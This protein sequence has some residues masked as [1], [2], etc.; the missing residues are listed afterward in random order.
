MNIAVFGSAFNPPTKGHEDAIH[1]L[2][3]SD[4]TFDCIFLIPSYRHAFDKKMLDYDT[5]KALLALFVKDINQNKVIA[6]PIE[7]ELDAGDKPVYTY[8]LLSHLENELGSTHRLTFIIGPDNAANWSKFYMADEIKKRW[9]T[10]VVPERQA[11]RSTLVRNKIKHG[12][13]IDELVSPSVAKYIKKNALYA[14]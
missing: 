1:F 12:M 9:G 11:I 5:R 3:S 2:L 6:K 4:Q 13:S 14:E 7:H 10:F 8:N